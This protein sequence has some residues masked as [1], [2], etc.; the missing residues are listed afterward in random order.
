MRVETHARS[1]RT[2]SGFRPGG[3]RRKPATPLGLLPSTI[4]QPRVAAARRPWAS[5]QNAFGVRS[6]G[7]AKR[8]L[9]ILQHSD[10]GRRILSALENEHVSGG[11]GKGENE[12]TLDEHNHQFQVEIG[13]RMSQED[14]D[15]AHEAQKAKL[16]RV[17]EQLNAR[18]AQGHR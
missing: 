13:L 7:G 2:P 18:K 8:A 15:A 12:Q 4:F 6:I 1:R 3:A 5:R 17:R 10:E 11:V 16:E 14:E 9:Q